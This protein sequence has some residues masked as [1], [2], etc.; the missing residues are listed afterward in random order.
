[1][2]I[3][4]NQEKLQKLTGLLNDIK[5]KQ[6]ITKSDFNYAKSSFNS[7]LEKD[8]REFV[9]MPC[10]RNEHVTENS[11]KELLGE[12][13]W[14]STPAAHTIGKVLQKMEKIIGKST[15]SFANEIYEAAKSLIAIYLPLNEVLGSI[16]EKLQGQIVQRVHEKIEK[17]ALKAADPTTPIPLPSGSAIKKIH[18]M[19]TEVTMP[20][21]GELRDFYSEAATQMLDEY[22]AK[23]EA[24]RCK[25]ISSLKMQDF[26]KLLLTKLLEK[27]S[28][29][30][31]YEAK[32]NT[33]DIITE[34][35]EFCANSIVNDYLYK[36]T[37]K[38]AGI[39]ERMPN[40]VDVKV[41]I[42]LVRGALEGGISLKFDDG[43]S[44]NVRS[45]TVISFTQHGIVSRY[46]TTFHD[47]AEKG[48]VIHKMLSESEMY[49]WIGGV[50]KNSGLSM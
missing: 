17:E 20:K 33:G 39:I 16:D 26:S 32:K 6:K 42:S 27:N 23:S 45:K 48:V 43:R 49:D 46:P 37:G 7:S 34:H 5:D 19:L 47:I 22:L 9:A 30:G 3:S 15:S 28:H 13:Y 41:S 36:H 44:F 2:T 11:D 29:K 10:V 8:W 18:T 1:M 4:I 50:D 21:K 12:L 31:P 24:E 40:E 14:V 25:P 35:A 38:L